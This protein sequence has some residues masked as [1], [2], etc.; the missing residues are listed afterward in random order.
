M[1]NFRMRRFPKKKNTYGL[2]EIDDALKQAKLERH[3]DNFLR[4]NLLK[5]ILSFPLL[6]K[7]KNVEVKYVDMRYHIKVPAIDAVPV[8]EPPVVSAPVVDAP[9]IGSS[10]S[11]TKIRVVVVRV[12]SQVVKHGKMLLKL[13]DHGKILHNHGKMLERIL[14]STVR[15]STLPL[16]D[17]LLLGQYQFSTLEKIV[18][19]KLE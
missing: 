17:T 16:G 11:T 19:R 18:K 7:G 2:S 3:H 14:M 6:N 10:S 4:L 9:V 15:Y 12:C 5:I 13:D 8:I 1:T